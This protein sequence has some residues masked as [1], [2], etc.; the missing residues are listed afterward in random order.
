MKA[1]SKLNTT[2]TK[3]YEEVCSVATLPELDFDMDFLQRFPVSELMN[4]KISFLHQTEKFDWN[5][6]WKIENQTALWNFNL[7]YFEYLH[8][9]AKVYLDTGK[10][11]ICKK[12]KGYSWL[13]TK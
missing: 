12:A 6:K 8:P 4:G 11:N 7:H 3:T 5:G 2:V 9:L 13:D 10:K 1:E